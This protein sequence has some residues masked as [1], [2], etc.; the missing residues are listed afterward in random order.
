MLLLMTHNSNGHVY[1]V[2]SI[3]HGKEE[4]VSE[5]KSWM[6]D[7]K[8]QLNAGKIEAMLVTSSHASSADSVPTSVHVGVSDVK[9]ACQS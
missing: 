8:L 4:C 2:Q 1:L 9:F 7:N 5:V 3:V 6:T